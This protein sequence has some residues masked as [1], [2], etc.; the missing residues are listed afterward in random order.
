MNESK[1]CAD[2]SS[3]LGLPMQQH[4]YKP[5]SSSSSS[6]SSS[7][8]HSQFSDARAPTCLWVSAWPGLAWP[9]LAWPVDAATHEAAD[10]TGA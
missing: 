10:A 7:V 1:D 9:G 2:C 8:F 5:S 3:S 6:S 4:H